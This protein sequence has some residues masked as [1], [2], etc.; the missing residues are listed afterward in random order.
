MNGIHRGL[1]L[2]TKE[3]REKAVNTIISYFLD[4]RDEEIGIVAASSVLDFVEQELA[5][6]IYN[7][8][9]ED[10]KTVLK[11]EQEELEFKLSELRK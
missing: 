3:E 10:I 2:F 7:R 1:N 4:E 8:A 6:T 11:K 5:P 9:I